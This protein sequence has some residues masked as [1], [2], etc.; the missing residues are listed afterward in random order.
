MSL[1]NQ[2]FGMNIYVNPVMISHLILIYHPDKLITSW[3]LKKETYN[4]SLR[5]DELKDVL[6]INRFEF[7]KFVQVIEGVEK[8]KKT[9]TPA[10]IITSIM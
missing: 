6:F 4:V 10:N 1:A 3:L 7:I 9:H 8:E 5:L 2:M